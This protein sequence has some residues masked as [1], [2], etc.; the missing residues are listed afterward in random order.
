MKNKNLLTIILAMLVSLT[1]VFPQTKETLVRVEIS[2][3]KNSKG[4]VMVAIWNKETYYLKPEKA[5]IRTITSIQ[6]A[7]LARVV[8]LLPLGEYAIAVYH[9][10]NDNGTQDENYMGI[11]EEGFGF[12]GNPKIKYGPASYK[13]AKFQVNEAEL[14]LTIKMIYL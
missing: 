10:E 11:P 1:S 8:F 6:S 5:I 3:L 2:N 13:A 9:D 7:N 4:S 12:S 14:A